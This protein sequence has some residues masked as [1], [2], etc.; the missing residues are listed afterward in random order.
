M[1]ISA[2][3]AFAGVLAAAPIATAATDP[4][5]A[6][7]VSKTNSDWESA[8]KKGDAAKIAAP[9]EAEAIFVSADGTCTRGRAAIEQMYRD[10][11][12]NQGLAIATHIESRK[13][14]QDGDYAYE[15]GY[16]ET[17]GNR[18]AKMVTSGGRY[19]TVWRRGPDGR[20][21]ILRNVVLP[22][23]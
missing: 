12:A 3:L 18:L 17:T 10:R 13:L 20:W 23:D 11:F 16:G 6:A 7:A 5:L 19:L 1:T 14:V 21:K 2:A 9:Y 4:A 22:G 15:W 8:M